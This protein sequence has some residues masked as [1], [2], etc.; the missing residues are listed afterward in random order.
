MATQSWNRHGLTPTAYA[1][2]LSDQGGRCA[3]CGQA[4]KPLVVDHD[5]RC[6]PGRGKA[7]GAC[8][9]GLLCYRC[10]TFLAAV[11]DPDWVL[12]AQ[13]YLSGRD[14]QWCRKGHWL[15]PMPSGACRVCARVRAAKHYATRGR[16][17]RQA[18]RA[19]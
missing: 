7:C 18:K 19:A 15:E 3:V 12:A 2:L 14:R 6:C 11:E 17:L 5:H 10:N 4:D 9:R 8:V 13:A 16:A 1:D